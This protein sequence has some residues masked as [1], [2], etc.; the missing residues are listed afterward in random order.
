MIKFKEI[1][2]RNFLSYGEDIQKFTFENF[3]YPLLIMGENRLEQDGENFGSNGAGKT[4]FV[5]AAYF[6][7]YDKTERRK[8][9]NDLINNKNNK[10]LYVRFHFT[11]N[12]KDKTIF[13]FRNDDV[14]KNS[15]YLFDK[16]V[17][18]FD[19]EKELEEHT[20]K[21]PSQIVKEIK[22][23]IKIESRSFL[24]TAYFSQNDKENF[25]EKN[26]NER[27]EFFQNLIPELETF[28]NIKD[29][30]KEEIKEIKREQELNNNN[31]FNISEIIKEKK[32]ELTQELESIKEK[33][34][35]LKEKIKSNKEEIKN[36]ESLDLETMEKEIKDLTNKID[37]LNKNREEKEK[38][39]DVLTNNLREIKEKKNFLDNN[40]KVKTEL[41]IISKQELA[42]N[43]KIQNLLFK[44]SY[45][46][47]K[48]YIFSN[49]NFIT[50]NKQNLQDYQD[51]LESIEGKLKNLKKIEEIDID[52]LSK[53]I[54]ISKKSIKINADL[55][56]KSLEVERKKIDFKNEKAQLLKDL[57]DKINDYEKQ[58]ITLKNN[59]ENLE[60]ELKSQKDFY[61]EKS[62]KLIKKSE[63]LNEQIV[64]MVKDNKCSKCG[65]ELKD[66]KV[67][68]KDEQELS[69]ISEELKNLKN[70]QEKKSKKVEEN[71]IQLEKKLRNIIEE[72]LKRTHDINSLK[73]E[74]IS[75]KDKMDL[76]YENYERNKQK[77]L[78]LLFKDLDEDFELIN[79]ENE[80]IKEEKEL[81]IL[82]ND[83]NNVAE[84]INELSTRK[85]EL[86]GKITDVNNSLKI[87]ENELS[88]IYEMIK[89]TIIEDVREN[90]NKKVELENEI[91]TLNKDINYFEGELSK[92]EKVYNVEK[93]N[94]IEK[95]SSLKTELKIQEQEYEKLK[96][97]KQIDS[98]KKMTKSIKEKQN[99]EKKLN[100]KKDELLR[101]F[102]N[103]NW[104]KNNIDNVK[105]IFIIDIAKLFEEKVNMLLSYFFNRDIEIVLDKDLSYK[106]IFEGVENTDVGVFSGGE[107]K[108]LNLATNFA[109]FLTARQISPTPFNIMILDEVLDTNLDNFGVKGIL[110]II[111]YI[112]QQNIQI[113]V[114]SHKEDYID[115]F[116]DKLYITKKE[117][118][119][120][121][122]IYK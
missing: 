2:I 114:I 51:E 14:H 43:K 37:E 9:L 11:I 29:S 122:I 59:L 67:I 100:D 38:N 30:V 23:L 53:K 116:N 104:W 73:D 95:L 20:N 21:K 66:N 32:E 17:S 106:I 5:E 68:E 6:A 8:N 62:E 102:E 115:N 44:S 55:E 96:D 86:N 94:K 48:N 108:R 42:Q 49:S 98:I 80:L 28:K 82:I 78:S 15:T 10:N 71:I 79:D 33:K 97:V 91:K 47:V 70:E 121:Y 103:E 87:K 19:L 56:K 83:K 101:S 24:Q 60:K 58:E 92:K 27:F 76:E 45:D 26:N 61:F 50:L 88:Y 109:L 72:K 93:E 85:K 39:I 81:N 16:N 75:F 25:F 22:D 69:L 105:R 18:L 111:E 1:E 3:S 35:E 12:G 90:N 46:D 120:S 52:M 113:M 41:D 64:N 31:I 65:S 74:I 13:K 7:L 84:K 119:F 110:K 57:E 107:M 117:N 99:E 77:E 4:T 89:T 34:K 54:E 118:G 63:E 112:S 40:I 36:L